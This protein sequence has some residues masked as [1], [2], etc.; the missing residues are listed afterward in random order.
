MC[1][2]DLQ[3]IGRIDRIGQGFEIFLHT[4]AAPDSPKDRLLRWYG[5]ALRI[6]ARPWHGDHATESAFA[7][8]LRAALVA[9]SSAAIDA[10]IE[11]GVAHNRAITAELEDGR[12]RLLELNSFDAETAARLQSEIAR[13]ETGSA[14]EDFMLEAFTRGGLDVEAIDT[15]SHAVRAGSE[16]H[17]PFPGFA[18][19]EMGVTFDRDVALRHPE[20]LFLNWDHLMVRDVLDGLLEGSQ[21]NA[22]VARMEGPTPG[23][24]LEALFVAE[25]ALDARWRADRFLPPT[26][27]HI[28]V[29][30]QGNAVKLDAR[31]RHIEPIDPA[32]LE[33]LVDQLEAVLPAQVQSARQLA[34]ARA[35]AIAD[36]ARAQMLDVLQPQAQRLVELAGV[37]DAI[38]EEEL[39]ASRAELGALAEG[40]Q[41]ARVR[42]DALRLILVEAR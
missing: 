36:S 16:Y 33:H 1:S 2:S 34:E 37:N 41:T 11:E 24:L 30:V 32:L 28:V 10:L 35:G 12:D 6:F 3:A 42:L 7:K 8:Q 23:L 9:E 31:T 22:A 26:P 27:I 14:L 21:G 38:G 5:E 17:H 29:D 4:A 15:R 20:R 13:R 39:A 40:L 19:E 25:H 18:G